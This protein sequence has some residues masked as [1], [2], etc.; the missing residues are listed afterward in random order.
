M[1]RYPKVVGIPF[2]ERHAGRAMAMF[3]LKGLMSSL[4]RLHVSTVKRLDPL[5]PT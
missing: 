5:S 1:V 4:S 3:K 2:F